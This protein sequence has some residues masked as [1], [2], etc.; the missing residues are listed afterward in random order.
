MNKVL[1]SNNLDK[2]EIR[3]NF[4]IHYMKNINTKFNKI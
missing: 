3:V 2:C 1:Y 4:Q